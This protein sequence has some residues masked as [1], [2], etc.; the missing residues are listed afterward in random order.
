M[1]KGLVKSKNKGVSFKSS[2]NPT[3]IQL[4]GQVKSMSLK[5]YIHGIR[6]SYGLLVLKLG[7]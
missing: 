2:L 6:W 3:G 1:H 7:L 5:A 4:G